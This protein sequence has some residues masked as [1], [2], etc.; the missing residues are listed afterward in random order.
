MP[1]TPAGYPYPDPTAQANGAYTDMRALAL[2]VNSSVLVVSGGVFD[3][4]AAAQDSGQ[5]VFCQL[6]GLAA[7]TAGMATTNLPAG[8]NPRRRFGTMTRPA[9]GGLEVQAFN[10]TQPF[11]GNYPPSPDNVPSIPVSVIGWAAR[12]A[13]PVPPT[14]GRYRDV[15]FWL[16]GMATGVDRLG[17]AARAFY[18]TATP[19]TDGSFQV[20]LPGFQVT[21]AILHNNR[22]QYSSQFNITSGLGSSTLACEVF[23]SSPGVPDNYPLPITAVTEV[24]G[25]AVGFPLDV[26]GMRIGRRRRV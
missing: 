6:P 16:Q 26:N 19:A 22:G 1:N 2:A 13:I 15:P 23:T 24:C 14:D 18:L 9:A 17:M 21:A 10:I 11:L 5:G 4:D 12:P 3:C 25:L 7:P 20:D 8:G